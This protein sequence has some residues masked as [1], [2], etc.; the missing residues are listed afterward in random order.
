MEP[1][2]L[3]MDLIYSIAAQYTQP[4][5]ILPL[6][7]LCKDTREQLE[8]LL[9]IKDAMMEVRLT[10]QE[11]QSKGHSALQWAI[12]KQ[13]TVLAGKAFMA[14]TQTKLITRREAFSILSG[15]A[16]EGDSRVLP[17]HPFDTQIGHPLLFRA[18]RQGNPI[19]VRHLARAIASF[20][21]PLLAI[22][23]QGH[24]AEGAVCLDDAAATAASELGFIQPGDL[25][26]RPG[27][28]HGRSTALHEC[29]K[30]GRDDLLDILL[31][32]GI[33]ATAGSPSPLHMICS[34]IL[35]P[36]RPE[37]AKVILAHGGSHLAEMKHE[38]HYTPLQTL[39]WG[40]PVQDINPVQEL[41]EL[42]ISHGADI[43]KPFPAAAGANHVSPLQ[44]VIARSHCHQMQ[45]MQ[46]RQL[47]DVA[48]F[49]IQNGADWTFRYL[50]PLVSPTLLDMAIRKI[51]LCKT[52]GSTLTDEQLINTIIDEGIKREEADE[53]DMLTEYLDYLATRYY[54]F[55]KMGKKECRE[56]DLAKYLVRNGAFRPYGMEDA[57]WHRLN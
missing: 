37:M 39:V 7:L 2:Q 41:L 23:K 44:K 34:P 31:S 49:L 5:D 55:V 48:L 26:P 42:L 16:T 56:F 12:Y 11:R 8:R 3:P 14:I 57:L 25:Q 36:R 24:Y 27:I 54:G 19:L 10:D 53:R 32:A 47:I 15:L 13:N 29:I 30:L 28:W 21:P 46:A 50:Q 9:H 18:V 33:P 20:C 6:L 45:H 38:S 1:K 4:R 22:S 51:G 35:A 40:F 17:N 43:N 52:S